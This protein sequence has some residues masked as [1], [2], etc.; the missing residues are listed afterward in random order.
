MKCNT[1][2][3]NV[4]IFHVLAK[5]VIIEDVSNTIYRPRSELIDLIFSAVG[6]TQDRS[7]GIRDSCDMLPVSSRNTYLTEIGCGVTPPLRE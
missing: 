2:R 7:G 4:F 5:C 1:A 6:R 3:T